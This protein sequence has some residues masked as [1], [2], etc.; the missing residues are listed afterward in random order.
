MGSHKGD[1]GEQPANH[2]GEDKMAV[3]KSQVDAVAG[4]MRD[5]MGKLME[6]EGKLGD[7]ELR[8]DHLQTESQQFQK[9]ADKV[10]RQAWLQNMKMK[11]AIGGAAILLLI[12]IIIV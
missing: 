10:K 2:G 8:A 12:I 11:L 4:M 5:N 7:L 1:T 9:T 3:T 6:R